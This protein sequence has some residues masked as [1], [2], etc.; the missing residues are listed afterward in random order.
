MRGTEQ[1][2]PPGVRRI[3]SIPYSILTV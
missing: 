1:I 2:D 3:S